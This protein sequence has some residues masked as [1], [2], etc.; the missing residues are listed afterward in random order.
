MSTRAPPRVWDESDREAAQKVIQEAIR[1]HDDQAVP[2]IR[3]LRPWFSWRAIAD[4]LN[5]AGLEP[6]GSRYKHRVGEHPGRSWSHVA[7]RRIAQR[8]GIA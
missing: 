2:I 8:N 5:L 7:V 4:R 3:E 1:T 6:P